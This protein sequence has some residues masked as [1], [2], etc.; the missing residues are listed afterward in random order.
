[1]NLKQRLKDK[2]ATLQAE[3]SL[4]ETRDQ[5][6]FEL[7]QGIKAEEKKDQQLQKQQIQ[8]EANELKPQMLY[9]VKITLPCGRC[10]KK[11][12]I[13]G[14]KRIL[15][16]DIFTIPMIILEAR[17]PDCL[18]DIKYLENSHL[19]QP[20]SYCLV[21]ETKESFFSRIMRGYF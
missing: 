4:E 2:L 8:D 14:A 20:V 16:G 17:C 12:P 1:M 19:K 9:E 3:K 7:Q 15:G 6:I 18:V 21:P 11:L 13:S 5:A 10:K